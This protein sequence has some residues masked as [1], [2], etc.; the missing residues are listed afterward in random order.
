[1]GQ[2]RLPL[3]L[4]VWSKPLFDNFHAG[5]IKRLDLDFYLGLTYPTAK[6]IYRFLDKRFHRGPRWEFD[7]E[8]FAFEHVGLSRSYK[9][10]V[11]VRRKLAPAIEELERK[12]FLEPLPEEER[13]VPV[14]RGQWKVVFIKK[15][16]AAL[17]SAGPAATAADTLARQLVDRGVTPLVAG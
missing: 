6:R 8:E 2:K 17:E 10:A 1:R 16:Q 5:Y 13:Y 14:R 7:L 3:S 15:A 4:F 12:G 9:K 11:H